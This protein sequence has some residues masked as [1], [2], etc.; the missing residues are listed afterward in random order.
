MKQFDP[1]ILAF[2]QKIKKHCL[3]SPWPN[4]K[5]AE[6]DI[7]GEFEVLMFLKTR[8]RTDNERARRKFFNDVFKALNYVLYKDKKV[9]ILDP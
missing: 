2:A 7:A 9:F 4:T 8:G 1:H 5:Q 3:E 6:A